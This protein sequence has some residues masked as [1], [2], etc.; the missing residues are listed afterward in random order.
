MEKAIGDKGYVAFAGGEGG[1]RGAVLVRIKD[2]KAAV[3]GLVD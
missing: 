2:G 3:V 1:G